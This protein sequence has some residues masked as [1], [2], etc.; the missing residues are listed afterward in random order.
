[1]MDEIREDGYGYWYEVD[2]KEMQFVS[3]EEYN[4]Y[5]NDEEKGE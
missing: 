5:T 1:M 3:P 4:E 2:G